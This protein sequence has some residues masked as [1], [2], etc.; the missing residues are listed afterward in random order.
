MASMAIQGE[1]S[2]ERE[3]SP[4]RVVCYSLFMTL[5]HRI[6]ELFGLDE[7]LKLFML[8]LTSLATFNSIRAL[9]S[10]PSPWL[11]T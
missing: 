11:F 6:T 2:W 8:L 5:V 9:S 1:I 3:D 7:T 10:Y 4:G